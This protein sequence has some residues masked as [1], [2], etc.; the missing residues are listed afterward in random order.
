M[1]MNKNMANISK[2]QKSIRIKKKIWIWTKIWQ[3]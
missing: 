3:I 2:S 1:D